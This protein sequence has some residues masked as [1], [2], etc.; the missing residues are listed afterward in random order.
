MDIQQIPKADLLDI[1]FD[2]R[3]K[4]YGAYDLRRSYNRRLNRAIAG[5]LAL[6]LLLFIGFTVAGNEHHTA[7]R[8]PIIDSITLVNIDPPARTP[9]PP[10]PIPK[11][12]HIT[13]P[14]PTIRLVT[15]RIV[16]DDK[17]K[18]DEKPQPAVV[19][20]NFKIDVTTNLD[21]TGADIV[22]PLSD[23]NGPGSNVINAP[24]KSNDDDNTVF[25][26]VEIESTY[27]GGMAAWQRF[28]LKNFRV[29]EAPEGEEAG[30]A[31]VVVQF[32][33]D[34][35]GN[36]SDAQALSGPATLQKEALRVIRLSGKWE[37]AIQNGRPV[38]SYKKQPITVHWEN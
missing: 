26:K 6:C 30:N 10:L 31:T 13:P 17:V 29:P 23:G 36:V 9:I 19:P 15:T 27:R 24:E 3:N 8:L 5:T 25:R 35:E 11:P 33:V 18:P 34:K 22:R 12:L 20:D 1:L 37:P 14:A 7:S 32:I 2:G 16:P 4:E 21:A 28:L 38:R